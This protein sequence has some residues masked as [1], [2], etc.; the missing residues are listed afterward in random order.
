MD[1]RNRIQ[2]FIEAGKMLSEYQGGDDESHPLNMPARKAVYAN[3]WFTAAGIRYALNAL[4]EAMSP[5]NMERW[6]LPYM[7]A[8][9]KPGRAGKSVGVVTAGN[10]PLAGFHDF[11]CVLLS[12]N[13]FCGRLSGQDNVLLPAIASFMISARP[14]WKERIRFTDEPLRDVDAIIATGSDNTYRYFEYY[15]SRF[16]HILRKNR[17]GVAILG[18]LESEDELFGLASDVM[19]YFGLGCR[20]VARLYVPDDY[21][22]PKLLPFFEPWEWVIRHNKYFNNY[23]YQKSIRIVNKQ[24]F[25]DFGNLMLVEEPGLAS[26]VSVLRYERYSSLPALELMLEVQKEQLQCVVSGLPLALPHVLPGN[27]Q[28]PELWDYADGSDTLAFLLNE[29]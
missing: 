21:D 10:I 15:F 6:L 25:F 19:L 12:G 24:A 8:L 5:A 11:M 7:H 16:P 13:E 23:E 2:T 22:L 20:S 27:A 1:I 4:G 29:I 9:E 14:E 28:K 17:N 3:P 26:P 18:G